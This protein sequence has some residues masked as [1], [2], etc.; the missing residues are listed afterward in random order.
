MSATNRPAAVRREVRPHIWLPRDAKLI[1][2]KLVKLQPA[3]RNPRTHSP[4]QVAALAR[5]IE[6]FGFINRIVIDHKKNLL[7]G[8]AR[9]A[10]AKLL[11]MT[12]VPFDTADHLTEQDKQAYIIADNKLALMA[13]WD[14]A[15]LSGAIARLREG[16]YDT[17]VVPFSDEELQRII[18]DADRARLRV[19][20]GEG[21]ADRSEENGEEADDDEDD[22]EAEEDDEVPF[23]VIM[24]TE[25]R[26]RVYAALK[27]VK[28]RDNINHSAQALLTI[29]DEWRRL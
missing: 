1:R 17:T 11:G 27:F 15:S 19:L 18:D 9:L 7:A 21:R 8:H 2:I 4:E 14:P 10:A 6:R 28:E 26:A 5:A 24:G 13:E 22:G 25:E 12:E 16:G 23:T 29:I 3:D 20:G